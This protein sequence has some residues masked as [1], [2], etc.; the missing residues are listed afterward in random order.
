MSWCCA[1]SSMKS[2]VAPMMIYKV[3]KASR[4]KIF[5]T[6]LYGSLWLCSKNL[7]TKLQPSIV[8]SN[9]ECFIG[10]PLPKEIDALFIGLS[11]QDG[12]VSEDKRDPQR[13]GSRI[14][15]H[16]GRKIVMTLQ[17][18]QK[19]LEI[20]LKTEQILTVVGCQ[21]ARCDI[22]AGCQLARCDSGE[23]SNFQYFKA[24]S[25]R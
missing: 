9:L 24:E 5:P 22:V 18:F 15:I 17:G 19:D 23:K 16:K 14:Q 20:S 2:F 6:R 21:L 12:E 13:N 4:D 25:K 1:R 11:G 8:H 3:S 10:E 7:Q